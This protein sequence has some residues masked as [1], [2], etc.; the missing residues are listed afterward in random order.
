MHD[1]VSH[2]HGKRVLV[3]GCTGLLGGATVRALLAGG[4]TVV[5]LV[6]EGSLDADFARHRLVGRIHIVRGRAE[7]LFRIHSALA[8]HEVQALFH[9]ATADER[10]T[11]AVLEAARRH[12]V[13][14]PVIVARPRQEEA[15]AVSL[16]NLGVARFGELFGRGDRQTSH[17]IP[18]TITALLT[19]E[20]STRVNAEAVRD[21]VHAEDAARACLAL[22]A[23]LGERTTPGLTEA[24]FRS[25][26]EFSD[27]T[28]AVAVRDAFE[29]RFVGVASQLPPANPLNWSPA[30]SLAEALSET[31]SWCRHAPRSRFSGAHRA[32]L[33]RRTAA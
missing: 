33:Q 15:A 13:R 1:P 14:M 10:G 2:W 25:G 29:S 8:I 5:G 3:T 18:A 6:R 27:R 23:A 12:D 28:M 22:A 16:V 24:S 17:I 9:L 26:W 11:G 19:G 32:E 31:I 30:V 20:R 7:D 4:A 21:F